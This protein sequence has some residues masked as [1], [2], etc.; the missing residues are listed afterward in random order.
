MKAVRVCVAAILL[1]CLVNG[2]DY[3]ET[4][5]GN[6]SGNSAD[7]QTI[8][9]DSSMW[10]V[11]ERFVEYRLNVSINIFIRNRFFAVLIHFS[12]DFASIIHFHLTESTAHSWHQ[13]RRLKVGSNQ[14]QRSGRRS[15]HTICK[16]S[17]KITA[18]PWNQFQTLFLHVLNGTRRQR[19]NMCEL[20]I[21][22]SNKI[23]RV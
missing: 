16:T 23:Y 2:A 6:C 14:F 4:I 3:H 8:K 13:T 9:V 11:K 7:N 20:N 1:V 10:T 15:W 19:R 5:L 22:R 21:F 18:W 17:P 12:F